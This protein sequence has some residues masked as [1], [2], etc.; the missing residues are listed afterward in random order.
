MNPE[1]IYVI[2]GYD[3]ESML[4]SLHVPKATR[5]KIYKM[6]F[7]IDGGLKV[8]IN[9]STWTHAMGITLAELERAA[10]NA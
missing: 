1:D 10:R 7:C 2:Q 5:D 3:L 9:E 8:K 4:L 6:S